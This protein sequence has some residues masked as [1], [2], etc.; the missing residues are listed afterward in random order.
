MNSLETFIIVAALLAGPLIFAP[1]EH[2]LETYCFALGTIA[3]TVN[4]QWE[5][6]LV[7]YALADALPITLTVIAA[8]LLFGALGGV[9][10]TAFVRMRR[11]LPRP[12]LVMVVLL[13]LALASSVITTIVAA[14]ILAEGVGLMGLGPA[15]RTRV[16]VLGCPAIGLGSAL[17]PVGEPLATLATSAMELDFY[18]L[19]S[20]AVGN[21]RDRCAKRCCG[22]SCP[23][24]V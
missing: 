23:R 6:Q 14:L 20:G 2:N 8:G 4:R 22:V 5:W 11:R 1:L 12:L 24:S 16:V 18:G 15:E 21:S 17:T 13:A 3:V 10:D 19:S 7:R 9:I